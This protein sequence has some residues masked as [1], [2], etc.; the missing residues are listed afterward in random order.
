MEL[1]SCGDQGDRIISRKAKK[2]FL[3]T[4]LHPEHNM[5]RVSEK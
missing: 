2:F 3:D 1:L 4:T 5:E